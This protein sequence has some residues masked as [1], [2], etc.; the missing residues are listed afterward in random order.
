MMSGRSQES[1]EELV[2]IELT[3]VCISAYR[4]SPLQV[5]GL[6]IPDHAPH[7]GA[8]SGLRISV[9]CIDKPPIRP[10]HGLTIAV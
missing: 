8:K 1:S 2:A 10:L 5:A 6:G 9:S 3:A 4:A 7:T